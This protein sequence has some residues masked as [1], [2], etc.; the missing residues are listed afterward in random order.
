M[1]VEFLAKFSK[2]LD[3]ISDSQLRTKVID[4]I[5]MLENKD[6]LSEI[7]TNGLLRSKLRSINEL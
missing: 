2:D 6:K 4:F 7:T 1:K 3:K 5:E